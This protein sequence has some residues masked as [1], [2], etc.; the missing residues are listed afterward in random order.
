MNVDVMLID[1]EKHLRTACEQALDLAGL[2]VEC[3]ASASD[4]LVG[5]SRSWSG[6]IVS[7]VKMPGI[8]GLALLNRVMALDPEIPVILMTGHGDVP[9][10]V[11]AM[12]DGAYDFIEKPFASGKLVDAV[13]RAL[14]KR[15]LVIQ[16]RVLQDAL[17]TVGPLERRIVGQDKTVVDLRRQVAAFGPIGADVLIF[18]ETGTGKE[19]VA[20]SLHE[21]S[22]RAEA[23]FVPINCGALP[24]SLIESELFG[25]EE[26]AFTGA[27]KQRLGKFEY[28]NGGTLFLDEIESM[29][30]ELQPRLLRVLQDRRI[31]RLGSN[32]ERPVDVRVIAATND[33]LLAAA[34]RGSFRTDLYYRLNVL[35]LSL[36]ALRQRR[37]DI[38]LLFHHFVGLAAIRFK[39][40]PPAV[41]TSQLQQLIAHDWPGNVRELENVAMR[42]ALGLGVETG[43]GA[44]VPAVTGTVV[45]EILTDKVAAY[46][47]G[48]IE[49]A[50]MAND[51]S[52]KATYQQLGLARKTLYDKMKRYNLNDKDKPE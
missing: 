10:A 49:D 23:R 35:S 5:L 22:P 20:R 7:D 2:T 3:H 47:K 41:S 46:E 45:G 44:A 25:H 11:D 39:C 18:G 33:D 43:A 51:G 40:T 38:A 24:E 34:G 12:R 30:V 17:D 48:L 42:F 50:L 27:S 32:T 52:I 13:R 31:V 1:D 28:A 36:P 19:L 26:G 29:P 37:P 4:A 16:N 14:E 6:V 21:L 8:D 15:R 9:M